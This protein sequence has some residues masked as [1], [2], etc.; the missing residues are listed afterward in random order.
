MSVDKVKVRVE[1]TSSPIWLS[2]KVAA[3]LTSMSEDWIE[4]EFIKKKR[5]PVYRDSEGSSMRFRAVDFWREWNRRFCVKEGE[6]VGS[7]TA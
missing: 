1:T 5:I 6:V 7:K 3:D 4:K 2:I